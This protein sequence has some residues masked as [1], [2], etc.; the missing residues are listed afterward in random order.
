MDKKEVWIMTI[1][2]VRDNLRGTIAGKEMF[3]DVIREQLERKDI[4]SLAALVATATAQ[5][6]EINI[7]ELKKILK[8]VEECLP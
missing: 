2:T 8:D 5:F 6:L 4:D 3:L 1:E 7:E